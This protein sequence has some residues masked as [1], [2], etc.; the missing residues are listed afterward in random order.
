MNK[1]FIVFE[2]DYD[3]TLENIKGI[4]TKVEDALSLVNSRIAIFSYWHLMQ[5]KFV[6]IA[7]VS[8][9]IGEYDLDAQVLLSERRFENLK[10]DGEYEA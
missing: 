10:W 5:N 9:A 7:S 3:A 2:N 8:D 1:V 6:T 4:F